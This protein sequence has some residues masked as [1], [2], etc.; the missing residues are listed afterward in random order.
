[1]LYSLEE[2]QNDLLGNTSSAEGFDGV[3][4]EGLEHII[5]DTMN[6]AEHYAVEAQAELALA[7]Q[8]TQTLES[9]EKY[10]VPTMSQEAD[11]DK[12]HTKFWNGLVAIFQRIRLA[13]ANTMKRIGIYMAGDLKKFET[14]YKEKKTKFGA[15][16]DEDMKS[17]KAKVLMPATGENYQKFIAA[18]TSGLETSIKDATSAA[19]QLS[20]TAVSE[21][22]LASAKE[23]I[24]D[25]KETATVPKIKELLY[26]KDGKAKEVSAD[27]FFKAVPF[28]TLG[29]AKD[30]KIQY[31]TLKSGIKCADMAI[32]GAK[33]N[34]GGQENKEAAKRAQQLGTVLQ[35]TLNLSSVTL[36]WMVSDQIR[37]LK[38][39][40]AMAE[41]VIGKAKS[42]DDDNDK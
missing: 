19:S 14:Y 31:K 15:A 26:G 10:V 28:E 16:T 21:D 23:L 33:K 3:E 42:K 24:K 6:D 32:K 37:F 29:K 38:V 34:M 9:F 25:V 40:K 27:E 12:I 35:Q 41:K 4:T 11:G 5:E 36:V 30:V 39:C 20:A 13:F 17:A 8:M 1:M 18:V 7:A 2:M 22:Q